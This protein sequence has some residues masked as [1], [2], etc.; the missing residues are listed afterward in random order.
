M[1]NDFSVF[2]RVEL[3]VHLTKIFCIRSEERA[4]EETNRHNPYLFDFDRA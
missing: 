4:E 3:Y 1:V 2:K